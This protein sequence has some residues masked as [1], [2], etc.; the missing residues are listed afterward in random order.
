MM[1]QAASFPGLIPTPAIAAAG[2]RLRFRR[3]IFPIMVLIPE[4]EEIDNAN[5]RNTNANIR[6]TPR[7]RAAGGCAHDSPGQTQ[8]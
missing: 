1:N 2:T 6:V 4:K 8:V 7:A 5:A 3:M